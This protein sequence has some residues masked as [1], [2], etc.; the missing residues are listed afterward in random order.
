MY[1]KYVPL[2]FHVNYSTREAHQD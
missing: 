1:K 2:I